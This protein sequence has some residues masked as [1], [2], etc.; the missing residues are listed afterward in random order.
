VDVNSVFSDP[1]APQE[2]TFTFLVNPLVS[3]IWLGAFVLTLGS[4]IALW[5]E[6]ERVRGAAVRDERSVAPPAPVSAAAD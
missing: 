5:P 1:N 4:L 3:L 6:A 2:A